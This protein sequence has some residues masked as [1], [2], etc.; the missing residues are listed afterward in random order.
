MQTTKMII[1]VNQNEAIRAGK[2]KYGETIIDI[3]PADLTPEQRETLATCNRGYIDGATG[4]HPYPQKGWSGPADKNPAVAEATIETAKYILDWRADETR[5]AAEAAKQKHEERVQKVLAQPAEKY[6]EF[7]QYSTHGGRYKY[8]FPIRAYYDVEQKALESDPRLADKIAEA[9][10]E[11]DRLNAEDEAR[12]AAEDAEK[13][14]I[15]NEQWQARFKDAIGRGMNDL[16]AEIGNRGTYIY[17]HLESSWESFAGK[18]P[19]ADE[20]IAM[21]EKA[22]AEKVRIAAEKEAAKRQQIDDYVA[23]H[24]TDNQKK[25][26]ALNLLPDDEVL[27]MMRDEV[28]APLAGFDRYEKITKHGI[29]SAG[30][31]DCDDDYADADRFTFNVEDAT[32]A[33]AE[34][35]E[36]MEK[37]MALMPAAT[38]TLRYHEGYCDKC[39][40]DDE[41]CIMTRHS[42]RVSVPFGAFTFSRE[43]AV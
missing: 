35:F 3:N 9:K 28:F 43:Y 1:N 16:I 18:F 23:A 31:C 10:R 21:I 8:N 29:M 42:I 14:R 12:K 25:R 41:E 34:D 11:I 38:V 24:G 15:S 4:D 26:A 37:I 32:Q 27:N 30:Y 33:T 22:K 20:F 36:Q 7:S 13:E 5:K 2:S 40:D 39:H 6:I 19:E 17:D